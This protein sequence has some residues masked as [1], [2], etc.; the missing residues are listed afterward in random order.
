[1]YLA[2]KYSVMYYIRK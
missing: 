2:S 1:M